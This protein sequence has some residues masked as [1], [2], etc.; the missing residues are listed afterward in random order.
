VFLLDADL[1]MPKIHKLFNLP[2]DQGLADVVFARA[3]FDWRVGI[4]EVRK[5]S[6][7]TAGNTPP[8]P[9][10]LLSSEKM[11]LFLSELEEIADVVI[12]DGPPLF[13]PDAMILAS[14]VDGVLMVVR[15]GHTRRT[16]AKAAMENIKLAGAKVVGVVLNRIPL[17]G[18]DYYADK[19]YANTY[20]ASSYGDERE[21]KEKKIHLKKLMKTLSPYANKPTTFIKHLFEAVFRLSPK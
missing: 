11:E 20:Y 12:I 21:G 13:V 5:V 19:S 10:E 18:A 9:A 17:R 16:L 7:L 4:R 6:V 15:P 14:K 1:R 2:N 3:V 8:D